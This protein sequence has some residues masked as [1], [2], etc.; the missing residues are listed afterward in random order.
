MRAADF[1]DDTD[2]DGAQRADL[3]LDGPEISDGGQA[4]SAAAF[5]DEA[6]ELPPEVA[7][8]QSPKD[9]F[10]NGANAPVAITAP[11]NPDIEAMLNRPVSTPVPVPVPEAE[12]L[13]IRVPQTQPLP[14]QIPNQQPQAVVAPSQPVETTVGKF[15]PDFLKPKPELPPALQQA[16]DVRTPFKVIEALQAGSNAISPQEL[17]G[18]INYLERGAFDNPKQVRDVLSLRLSPEGMKAVDQAINVAVMKSLPIKGTLPQAGAGRAALDAFIKGAT[19]N[20]PQVKLPETGGEQARAAIATQNRAAELA[21]NEN[22]A[23]HP[24][25]S[26]A[27]GGLGATVPFLQAVKLLR[28]ARAAAGAE[29][30]VETPAGFVAEGASVGGPLEFARR[31]EGSDAMS[32]EAELKARAVQGGVGLA[33]GAVFDYALGNAVNGVVSVGQFISKARERLADKQVAQ[34]FEE[35]ARAKGFESP[36]QYLAA[37]SEVVQTEQ[38]AVIRARPE[39]IEALPGMRGA[40]DQ[41]PAL[42]QQ[43]TIEGGLAKLEP[44]A[45]TDVEKAASDGEARPVSPESLIN[46]ANEYERL[47]RATSDPDV[48]RDLL[49]Q[50]GRFRRE[51]EAALSGGR[52]K[53]SPA[54]RNRKAKEIDPER[55]DLVTA[56]RKLGGIDIDLENDWAG[57]L[58]HLPRSGFGLPGVERKGGKGRS[59]DDLAEQLYQY[60]YL[61]DRNAGELADALARAETGEKVFALRKQDFAEQVGER[62]EYGA[63]DDWTW[64][65]SVD[66]P[67]SVSAEFVIDSE[68]GSLV[69]SR[70]IDFDDLT[71]I[72]R[73]LRDG[74]GQGQAGS[75]EGAGTVA[76]VR[77]VEGVRVPERGDSAFSGRA[78]DQPEQG[79]QFGLAGIDARNETQQQ[80][81][82]LARAREPRGYVPPSAGP[83]DLF[84]GGGRQGD[85]EDAINTAPLSER[86]WDDLRFLRERDPESLSQQERL[87]LGRL[88]DRAKRD[89][90]SATLYANPFL[91]SLTDYGKDVAREGGRHAA[92]A[93]VGGTIGATTSKEEPGSAKWWLDAVEGAAAGSFVSYAGRK[94]KVWGPGSYAEKARQALGEK[95]ERLPYVGRGPADVHELKRK[96][97][98]M[99]QLIDRQ[100]EDVGGFLAKNFTPSE[101]AQMADLIENRQV[102]RDMNRVHRQAAELDDFITQS[103]EKMKALK[104]LPEDLETGGYLHRYYAKHLGLDPEFKAAKRQTLSGTYSIARGT[105][106]EFN[107]NYFSPSAR[108]VQDE[109]R[110]LRE[111][112][113]DLTVRDD[114]LK[115]D[116]LARVKTLKGRL[117]ELEK[118]ALKEFVG[119]ENGKVKSFFFTADEAARI[120]GQDGALGR[121]FEHSE[122]ALDPRAAPVAP[123]GKLSAT[124]RVWFMR[125][126]QDGGAKLWRDWTEAERENWG[127]IKDAGY[128]YVRGMAE[129]S[130]DLSLATLF[131]TLAKRGDY[132]SDKP[133]FE[134]NGKEWKFV[135]DTKV[136]SG[137]PLRKYGALAGKYVR[138]DVWNAVKNYGR[139]PFANNRYGEVYRGLV[140][141]W[142]LY[143]TVYNP[144]S[145]VNNT[146]SNVEMLYMAGYSQADLAKGLKAWWGRGREW[147]EA[148]DAGLFGVDWTTSLV[149]SSEGG[150]NRALEELAE[151]L[152][153][154]EDIPDA[155]LSLGA[156]MRFKEAWINSANALGDAKSP[157]KTGT[158]LAKAMGGPVIKGLKTAKKPVDVATLAAQRLYRAE[159]EWFRMAVYQAERAKGKTPEESVQEATKFFFDYNDLPEAVKWVRDFPVGS[160]FISYTYLALPA[161]A[162]NLVVNPEKALALVMG[163]EAI[164]YSAMLLDGDLEPGEYWQRQADEN[165]LSAPWDQ[166]RSL[167][168][169]RNMV[170]VPGMEDYQLAMGR[171]HALGNPFMS[172]AGGREKLPVPPAAANFWGSSLLGSNPVHSYLDIWINEDWKGK[173]I[174]DEQAPVEEKIRAATSYLYQAFSPSNVLTP[175]SYHQQ[176]VL[177]GLANEARIAREEGRAT[178]AEP[179][180]KFANEVSDA[181]G[182]GE[183]TGKDRLDRDVLAR[184]AALGTAGVKLRKFDPETTLDFDL[185][186]IEKSSE[187]LDRWMDKVARAYGEDRI[188][189]RRFD[190]LYALYERDMAKLGEKAEKKQDAF[191]RLFPSK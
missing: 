160:P 188:S 127:E 7:P 44:I 46:R 159:D 63:D 75:G 136:N 184:D 151:T 41:K 116:A 94:L 153:T 109:M 50:A 147:E 13:S 80:L 28:G 45:L 113:R 29:P 108:A 101:R 173:P 104:M 39:V 177:E 86:D 56:I 61:R 25:A 111:E 142:K 42:T 178:L 85:I 68:F 49:E 125:D 117:R 106:E 189:E 154:Q 79:A 112:L 146:F 65:E 166:G 59:L 8:I 134:K 67:R 47:A 141:R 33:A 90:D 19:L 31:P 172:E 132:V 71:N 95:W 143:K 83:G 167:W 118:T 107:S 122:H 124:D 152:R 114:L 35:E 78:G 77:G 97:R 183:F 26:F 128:R 81:A 162:R 185:S 155:V 115:G 99:R 30:V 27:G 144:V 120:P 158:E 9:I 34:E 51:R 52:A 138:P 36:E 93:V 168:G 135:P 187:G 10:E 70:P 126:A 37:L 181:L 89:I 11:G 148:R 170:R 176:K 5:L 43:E 149:K 165:E 121:V 60:G 54:E 145:H 72:E 110:G 84:G 62:P 133:T 14:F 186:K 88:E 22:A 4:P 82:D 57:R 1:L 38:G 131:D 157:W 180:V 139:V 53:L 175:G 179:V 69:P 100:T 137:S 66:D 103:A 17:G 74:E 98:L 191:E 21:G 119:E 58:S 163:Y 15:L 64:Y 40:T 91:R 182:F 20:I 169:A 92:A 174:Y 55:D 102:V 16:P 156:V 76:D 18:V 2:T 96:Q 164:N 161:I 48:R 73:E 6:P 24:V 32:A 12:R 123:V 105:E 171:M 130:H 3:F 190:E 150:G 129:V 140:N 23:A 87:Q